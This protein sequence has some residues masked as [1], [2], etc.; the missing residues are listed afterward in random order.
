MNSDPI[1]I[2][3]ASADPATAAALADVTLD[4]VEAGGHVPRRPEGNR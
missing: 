4:C 1:R 3:R 2:R